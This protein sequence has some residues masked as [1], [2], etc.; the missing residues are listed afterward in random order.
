MKPLTVAIPYSPAPFFVKL[1]LS[2]AQLP[3]VERVIVV[4]QEPV[5]LRIPGSH[6]LTAAP[7]TAQSTLEQL[8]AETSTDNLLLLPRPLHVVIEAEALDPML[9]A[10]QAAREP[11][12]S[13]RISTTKKGTGRP[14]T[15]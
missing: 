8:L 4:A 15:P 10:A 13:I 9:A 12:W 1:L 7:I 14:F 11:A 2:L 5:H 3:A 6:I